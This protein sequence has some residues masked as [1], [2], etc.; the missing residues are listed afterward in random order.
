MGGVS[1]KRV[2]GAA[3]RATLV[4]QIKTDVLD[5]YGIPWDQYL[6]A[7]MVR[8]PDGLTA[9]VTFTHRESGRVLRV[10]NIWIGEF[11]EINQV[12]CNYGDLTL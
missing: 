3:L 6:P 10:S 4:R 2:R 5:G 1:V 12:G 7:R 9:E 11:G 8:D